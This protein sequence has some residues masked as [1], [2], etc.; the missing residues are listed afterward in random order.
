MS[1]KDLEQFTPDEIEFSE[2]LDAQLEQT[3][4]QLSDIG[5]SGEM[6]QKLLDAKK[7]A[8]Q[9]PSQPTVKQEI[10]LPTI[11]RRGRLVQTNEMIRQNYEQAIPLFKF[12]YL[13]LCWSNLKDKIIFS[14]P[15]TFLA[16]Y[17]YELIQVRKISLPLSALK[18]KKVF[19]TWSITF[20]IGSTFCLLDSLF[21]D[22]FCNI[23]SYHYKDLNRQKMLR[24]LREKLK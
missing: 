19:R 15:M 18:M 4:K 14:L 9:Q 3:E 20:L 11:D 10:D 23:D 12:T 13:P 17:T 7:N 16:A 21:F 5:I 2:K 8:P 6:I 22:E 1:D 24:E